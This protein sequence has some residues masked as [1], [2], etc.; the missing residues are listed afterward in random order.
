VVLFTLVICISGGFSNFPFWIVVRVVS[1]AL[2]TTVEPL[3][4]ESVVLMEAHADKSST[5]L[6]SIVD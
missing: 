6:K 3:L 1:S 2:L 4:P 5:V